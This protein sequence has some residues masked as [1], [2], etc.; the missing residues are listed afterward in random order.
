MNKVTLIG[1][2]GADV[3]LRFTPDGTAVCDLRVATNEDYKDKDGVKHETTEWHRIVVWNGQA[4]SSA[5]YLKKGSLV[6]IEGKLHTRTW[7]K[8]GEKRYTTEII[9]S[10]VEFLDSKP[11]ETPTT[12]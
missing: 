7:D 8:D 5:K 3:E 12:T 1:H 11:K 2:L 4:K 6:G 9:A 10:H